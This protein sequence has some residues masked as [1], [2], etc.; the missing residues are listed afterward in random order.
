MSRALYFKKGLCLTLSL[1]YPVSLKP[2]V[3]I[4]LIV[5]HV[6]QGGEIPFER[7][8]MGPSESLQ[9]LRFW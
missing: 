5:E 3:S 7:C 1:C 4:F 2:L 6:G 8:V 9:H